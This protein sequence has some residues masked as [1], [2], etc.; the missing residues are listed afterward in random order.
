MKIKIFLTVCCLFFSLQVFSQSEDDGEAYAVYS[1]KGLSMGLYLGSYFPNKYPASLYDG[2][3]YDLD[4][5]KNNFENSWMYTKI[6]KQYGF[7]AGQYGGIDVITDALSLSN[8]SDWNFKEEY[9]PINMRYKTAFSI[10]LN[11][12][13]SKDGRNG[14]I[15]NMNVSR[16]K[17]AGNFTIYT[18]PPATSTQINNS[19]QTFE[20]SGEEQRLHFQAGYQGVLGPEEGIQL[21]VEGGL[22]ATWAKFGKNEIQINNLVIDL[23]EEYTN[24]QGNIFFTGKKPIGLGFGAFAG[25]GFDVNTSGPWDLQLVYSPLLEKI[26]I[27]WEP[28]IKLSQSVALRCYYKLSNK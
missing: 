25:V 24:N 28:K 8:A 6:V 3:G 11:T 23:S 5:N 7:L 15:F 20:I 12:R 18:R 14:V 10:G 4:G 22:H 26:N 19:L 27:G 16:L 17:A 21:F 2:Y 9:M 13:F 1:R